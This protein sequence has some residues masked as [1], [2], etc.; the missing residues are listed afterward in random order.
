VSAVLRRLASGVVIGAL[1]LAVIPPVTASTVATVRDEFGSIA[2]D[3]DDGS[4]S[5][6]Y[7]W[8][9]IPIGDGPT[10]GLIRVI[11]DSHCA[12]GGC[13]RFGDE[14]LVAGIYR[15]ADLSGFTTA[16]LTY[17]YRRK[18]TGGGSGGL[19]RLRVSD[20]LWSWSNEAS[21]SMN[22]GDAGQLT[23]TVD[24]GDWV[25]GPVK[26]AFFGEGQLDGFLYVDNVQISM[27]SNRSPAFDE[28]FADRSDTEGDSIAISPQA[29]DPDDD[30][31]SFSAT[32]LPAG[33]SINT[34]TGL[35]AGSL[36]YGSAASSP[37]TT[38]VKV[39]DGLGGVDTEWFSWNVADRNRA[40]SLAPLAD[41]EVEETKAMQITVNAGDPDLP[42]DALHF[43]LSEAPSGATVDAGGRITWTPPE[44]AGPGRYSLTVKV[45]DSGSP[46]LSDIESFKIT[47]AEV[48]TVPTL[49]FIPDQ[50]NGIGNSVS[51]QVN[52]SDSDTPADTLTYS[53][54]GLPAGVSINPV[55][56][57]VSGTIPGNAAQSNSTV[58]ITVKDNGS[59][60]LQASR[61]FS[62]QV[63][64][65]NHAPVL[66]PLSEQRPNASGVVRFTPDASDADPGDSLNYWL[67]D[68]IDAVPS[69]ATIDSVSGRFT[70]TP[71]DDQHDATYRINVGVSDSGSPRLSDT[72]LVTIVVPRLNESPQLAN[73]ERQFSAEGESISLDVAAT[74]PDGDT[75]RYSAAGLPAGLR[76]NP[77]TGVI[78]GDVDFEAAAS[79][80]FDVTVTVTDSGSPQKSTAASFQWT[81]AGTNRPPTAA[82]VTVLVLVG[83]PREITLDAEDPDGDEL[84][85]T[86][87]AAPV[88][89]IVEGEA[90][91]L[92]YTTPGGAD[93]DSFSYLVSD[94]EFEVVAEVVVDVRAGNTPPTADA[95]EYEVRFE[96]LLRVEAPGV[97]RNDS[98]IDAE[99]LTVSLVSPPGHGTLV[100]DPDGSF[101]YMPDQE[102]AGGDKFSYAATDAFGEQATA[103]VILNVVATAVVLAPPIEDGPK[104]GV[105]VASTSLWQPAVVEDQPLASDM[106]RAVV[107]AVNAGITT[108]PEM[109][110][111]L[112]LLAIA[113]LLGLTIGRVSVLPLGGAKRE[114]I[115]WVQSYDEIHQ[116]GRVVS[117]DD[118]SEVFVHG[119]ALDRAHRIEAGQQV[120]FIAAD[121]RGR[122]IALKVWPATT[123]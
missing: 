43:S 64:Q 34:D 13:L 4:V 110:V 29:S 89:G 86:L 116:L 104:L 95:D 107:A 98:D 27:S 94:G 14:A 69:G 20:D 53:A 115:G 28:A 73:P 49:G 91:H 93:Q 105:V 97:L 81:V 3:G 23:Q 56:G 11:N 6:Q 80:P 15:E 37:Y 111:P 61:S 31:L 8:R 119:R 121:M 2:F 38:V 30:G 108:L 36:G 79:S 57:L 77:S 114:E 62:W 82:T 19:V 16:T 21:H 120:R 88:T 12:A 87:V 103:T 10:Q 63:T 85:Y 101:T 60:R 74:D 22:T 17:S 75:L 83:Q 7:D 1:V 123:A 92:V 5:W 66:A 106:K 52:G 45:I 65:G 44:T 48:N 59:P 42:S 84:E 117:E 118:E 47:V 100:L 40:P 54:V 72:Q 99:E 46:A 24:L 41:I 35:I 67:A 51:L 78:S 71:S 55:S 26:V 58:T 102:Y 50:A 33:I 32:G 70:W 112:L 18:M 113:L 76:I 109:K 90:P 9:E 68:G 96:E 25:G 122:R 39:S